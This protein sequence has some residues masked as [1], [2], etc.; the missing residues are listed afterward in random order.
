M[1]QSK[2]QRCSF[3]GQPTPQRK[4]IA[5]FSKKR[6]GADSQ[7]KTRRQHFNISNITNSDVS[8]TG[9]IQSSTVT[10]TSSPSFST[11]ILNFNFKQQRCCVNFIFKFFQVHFSSSFNALHFSQAISSSSSSAM[12][13]FS[14]PQSKVVRIQSTLAFQHSRRLL[15]SSSRRHQVLQAL[16]SPIHFSSVK[17]FQALLLQKA[18]SSTSSSNCIFNF[19]FNFIFILFVK[20][21]A[22][23]KVIF[24]FKGIFKLQH[25]FQRRRT[26]DD[27]FNFEFD[28]VISVTS[29]STSP[30][31]PQYV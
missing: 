17:H 5:F 7:R 24:N 21:Q 9:G 4:T 27:D 8:A 1:K 14:F 11:F 18:L 28:T 10:A 29:T 15:I 3:K 31:F 26:S 13:H 16:S 22:H 23:F 12:L 30:V 6:G 25:H 2:Q 20:F 19:N